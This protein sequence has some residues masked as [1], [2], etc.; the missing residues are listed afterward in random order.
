[1]ETIT[2]EFVEQ[3]VKR[4]MPDLVR[5][6]IRIANIKSVAELEN[7]SCPPYGRGCRD[8]L[9]EM[10]LMGKEYGFET[11]NYDN[12]VGC[13]LL[14]SL[15]EDVGIWAHLDV[16]EEGDGWVYEPYN[17]V[18]KDGYVIGRGV[19][20]NKSSAVIGL[21]VL[22]FLKEFQIPV[23]QNLKL[24]LGTCEEQQKLESICQAT[25]KAILDKEIKDA[26]QLG[27][28]MAYLSYFDASGICSDIKPHISSIKERIAEMINSQTSLE[29][30][31]QLRGFSKLTFFFP[32]KLIIK[33]FSKITKR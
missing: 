2:K 7:C 33:F 23:R 32:R 19:Q 15:K 8:V 16:V 29:E 6:L 9:D 26:Y 27:Y 1:M 5:D 21:Y 31:Y 24:Y 20:D 25:I 13:I 17:A 18:E 30:L 10:L 11:I 3:W 12:Y 14:N 28:S 4:Q 22:R